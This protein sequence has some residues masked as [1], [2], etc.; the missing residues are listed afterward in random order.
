M[1]ARLGALRGRTRGQGTTP[2]VLTI[3]WLD[4]VMI[5]GTWMPELVEIA[6]GEA[7]VTEPGQ[8]APTLTES[9]LSGLTPDVVMIKPCGFDLERTRSEL[10]PLKEL[11]QRLNWPA[12]TDGRTYLSDG[13]AFFNRPGPRLVESAEILAACIHPEAFADLQRKHQ[14]EFEPLRP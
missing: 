13:N 10:G 5:G 3:E 11:L 4:P 14:R 9:E 1:E 12:W 2:K 6:G 8:H 7:L